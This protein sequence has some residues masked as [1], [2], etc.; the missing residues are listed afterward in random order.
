MQPALC[1]SF[2]YDNA[3]RMCNLYDHNG[4]QVPAVLFPANE[5]DFF[6]RISMQGTCKGFTD[7]NPVCKKGFSKKI[8]NILVSMYKQYLLL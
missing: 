6:E 7:L 1:K 2:T 8:T 4:M 3:K 5:V